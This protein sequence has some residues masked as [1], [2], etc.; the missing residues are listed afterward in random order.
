MAKNQT[1]KKE[2]NNQEMRLDKWL[3]SVRI[4]KKREEA[5]DACDLGRVKVN[6]QAA[7]PGRMIK[8]KDE[9]SVK[10]GKSYRELTVLQIPIRGLSATDAK[11]YYSEVIPEITEETKLFLEMQK[12]AEKAAKRKFKGRPT[13]KERRDWSK[14]HG[15]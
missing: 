11:E 5:A 10:S 8:V 7:K 4:F 15:F 2:K 12:D 1:I 14:F 6:A 3:K 13:K 9:I